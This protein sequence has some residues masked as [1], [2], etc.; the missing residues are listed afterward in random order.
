MLA[1]KGR[2]PRP[3]PPVDAIALESAAAV[4]VAYVRLVVGHGEFR[5][6]RVDRPVR[7]DAVLEQ[8]VAASRFHRAARLVVDQGVARVAPAAPLEKARDLGHVVL[9]V[10]RKHVGEDGGQDD[11]VERAVRIRELVLGRRCPP[12]RLVLTV[13]DIGEREAHLRGAGRTCSSH[14]RIPDGTMSIPSYT[15]S[16]FM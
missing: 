13:V 7:R 9:H 2:P 4:Q 3:H 16:A 5:H 12:A 15:P 10:R 6:L 14:H 11:E 1:G 8:H